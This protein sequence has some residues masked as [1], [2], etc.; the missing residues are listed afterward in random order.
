MSLTPDVMQKL[1]DLLDREVERQDHEW[2]QTMQRLT[3]IERMEKRPVA[4][5]GIA[6]Q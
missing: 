3:N 1:R 5:N 4:L 6:D 2:M